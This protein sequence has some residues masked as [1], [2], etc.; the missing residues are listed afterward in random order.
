MSSTAIRD[1]GPSP[2]FHG[3]E[4][5]LSNFNTFLSE[6][7]NAQGG[8]T[9]L[10]QGAPGAGKTA[11]LEE[12]SV[13]ALEEDWKVAKIG[14][15]DLYTPASMAQSLGG[16]Y[17]INKEYAAEIG[18]KFITGGHVKNIAGHA[19]V[20]EILK[21]L[22]PERG[23]V[24]VLDEAQYLINLK[25]TP[26]EKHL[27]RDTLDMIHNGKIGRPVILLTAGLGTTLD[28]FQ[29]LGISRFAT[30]CIT[31]LGRL[32]QESER[33][34][35][36]DWLVEEGK[37]KEDPTHWIDVIAKQ[38]QGWPQHIACYVKIA[39]KH[40]KLNNQRLTV[41]G[42][43]FVLKKGNEL[44]MDYYNKRAHDFDAE[45]RQ[46]LARSIADLPLEGTTTRTAIMAKLMQEYSQRDADNLFNQA[47]NQ[48]IID[49][50]S[51]GYYG[52]PIPS[53]QTWLIDQYGTGRGRS[54][55]SQSEKSEQGEPEKT[56]GAKSR[57]TMER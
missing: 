18:V 32:D 16:A 34:V 9:F 20:E 51:D 6:S 21:Q 40:L 29:L 1:R 26:T 24:L 57:Y 42:L 2:Y 4:E 44:R 45:Q 11:L 22:S 10:I 33:N 38:S 25:D 28:G 3:R 15:K 54:V 52:I 27:A 5:I 43:E 12:L 36:R 49:R 50:R 35:I 14:I 41:D 8:S 13:Q 39:A 17:T 7:L 31:H 30:D 19:S 47:L 23:L 53:M 48:G 55:F 46:S 37:T 56:I